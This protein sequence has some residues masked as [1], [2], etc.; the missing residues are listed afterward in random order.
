MADQRVPV[1]HGLDGAA[2]R[3]L[4]GVRQSPQQALAD[5]AGSPSW[6]LAPGCDDRPATDR[7][8]G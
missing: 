1:Q 2:G 4:D 6:F 7:R 5:L 3:D 8:T